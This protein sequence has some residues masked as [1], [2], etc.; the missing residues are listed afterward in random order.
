MFYQK[1]YSILFVVK[2]FGLIND[3]VFFCFEWTCILENSLI[4]V[5][6]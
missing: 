3:H 4:S 1:L 2:K 5:Q 6:L